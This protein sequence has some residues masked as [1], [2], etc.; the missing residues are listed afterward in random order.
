MQRIYNQENSKLKFHQFFF[1]PIITIFLYFLVSSA[2]QKY[3][4]TYI[5]N[6]YFKLVMAS[7]S[8]LKLCGMDNS[9]SMLNNSKFSNASMK[10]SPSASMSGTPPK[11]VTGDYGYVL[12]DVP[13]FSDYI[14]NPP[15]CSLSFSRLYALKFPLPF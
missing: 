3:T 1:I 8:T 15:V 12:E 11:I 6:S 2:F 10:F 13:H 4:E 7:V 14:P 5:N 9:N